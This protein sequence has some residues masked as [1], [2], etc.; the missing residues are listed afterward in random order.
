MFSKLIDG[1]HPTIDLS[2]S[3]F[4]HMEKVVSE[5]EKRTYIWSFHL[6]SC[7][8]KYVRMVWPCYSYN[9]VQ[10]W[11]DLSLSKHYG[12]GFAFYHNPHKISR[13][14]S[15]S[16][17]LSSCEHKYEESFLEFEID[18]VSNMKLAFWILSD[19]LRS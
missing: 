12:V 16:F 7:E 15:W 9:S 10:W 1:V 4:K 2:R 5:N 3:W 13:H 11:T 6:S 18:H 17:H 14:L 19:R 8:H